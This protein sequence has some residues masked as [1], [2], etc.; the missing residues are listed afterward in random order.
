MF[1]PTCALSTFA[2]GQVWPLMHAAFGKNDHEDALAGTYYRMCLFLRAPAKLDDA[3]H[4]QIAAMAARSLFELLLDLKALA[5]DPG[6]AEKFLDFTWVSR[7]HK[8]KQ[9]ADFLD[10]NPGVDATPR[11]HALA[12]V[13]KPSVQQESAGSWGFLASRAKCLT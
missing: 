1:Q 5:K 12:L 10:A 13:N 11:K 4:F 3:C 9:L 6:L 7:Y 2:D 8:A